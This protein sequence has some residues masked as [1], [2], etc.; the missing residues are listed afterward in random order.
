[1][2]TLIRPVGSRISGAKIID[3]DTHV[4]EPPDLW[5]SRASGQLRDRVPRVVDNGGRPEWV[6]D[7]T[8]IGF[9]SGFATVRSDGG[10][11]SLEGFFDLSIYDV[12]SAAS[13][14]ASRIRLMDQM[15][16]YAQ[17]VYPNMAGF[18]G[19]RFASLKD[20]ALK[21]ACVAIYNDAMAEMTEQSLGRLLPMT[22]V[23]WWSVDGSV[24][25]LRRSAQMGSRG[26]VMCSDP[27]LRGAPDLGDRAWD[28]FW[29]TCCEF[30]LPVN[31]HIGATAEG[32]ESFSSGGAS[33]PSLGRAGNMIVAGPAM[34]LN[35]GRVL[36]NM[37]LSGVLERFRD[38]KLVS[39]ESGVG[40]IPFMM[41]AIDHQHREEAA[42]GFPHLKTDPSEYI[43]DQVYACFFFERLRPELFESVRE[44]NIMFETD[45]PHPT[46]LYPDYLTT[47]E[48]NVDGL[49]D[50]T[51][52]KL[53]T[54]NAARLYK[55]PL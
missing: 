12:I 47:L 40:W 31:F 27:H 11:E 14:P 35:N 53:V 28:P 20:E 51:V 25:E 54:E 8:P 39:V 13:D 48:K 43:R 44:D 9:A 46:C 24:D 37:V 41:E 34:F 19:E 18:G 10:K 33:W 30:D 55:I 15:G 3:A 22:L 36:M 49:P 6:I 7:G 1:M 32:V 21:R 2:T 45:F 4:T 42:A 38:L 16:I 26:V 50:A 52:A 29:E 17:I 5:T 23:P